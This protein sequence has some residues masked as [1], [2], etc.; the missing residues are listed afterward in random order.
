MTSSY[1]FDALFEPQLCQD[2]Y[3]VYEALRL[4]DPLYFDERRNLWVLCSYTDVRQALQDSRTFSSS[5]SSFEQTL[6]GADGEDHLRVRKIV[7]RHMSAD[8]HARL[9]EFIN[10]QADVLVED[11]AHREHSEIL[12]GLATDL[13]SR[14]AM[15]LLG[16]DASEAEIFS[17]YA[18]AIESASNHLL[19][20]EERETAHGLVA[21]LEGFLQHQFSTARRQSGLALEC[22][23]ETTEALTHRERLDVGM[24]LTVAAT[25]TTTS[26]ITSA[27]NIIAR[28]PELFQLLRRDVTRIPLFIEEVLR[29]ES[30]VQRSL[31]VVVRDTSF[32]GRTMHAGSNML[33]M[34]GAANRDP[35]KFVNAQ[36]FDALRQPNGHLSFGWGQ[37]RC[38]G[39][40]IARME[41]TSIIKAMVSKLSFV[42]PA[43]PD[44][45]K[46]RNDLFIR[47]PTR[48]DIVCR[49]KE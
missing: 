46:Y 38:I 13:P 43:R 19:P 32:R 18:N 27:V 10:V 40:S 37:H 3:P 36:R 33:L 49:K 16:L 25:Q 29:Y 47:I 15:Q 35:E 41:A 23:Y 5:P 11:I 45:I 31:R 17:R 14:V 21:E 8:L 7:S 42:A 28:E 39:R 26:L 44:A 9:R 30:T 34:L 48:L 4:I 2:P 24:L 20:S 1:P 12:A 22:L 6:L